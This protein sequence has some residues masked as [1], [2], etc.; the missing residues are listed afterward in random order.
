MSI[1]KILMIVS[2]T[3]RWDML[4]YNGGNV[5]T[6]NLDRLA[7]RSMVFERHYA[8]SFPTVPARYDYLTGKAAFADVGWGPLPAT[9]VSIASEM[10]TA[11]YTTLGVVDTPFYQANGY[12]YDR[13]FNFFYD[14]K[15]QLLGTPQYN[16]YSAPGEDKRQAQ[17][18]LP[19]FPITGKIKPDPRTGEVDCPAPI[20]ML[21]AAKCLEELYDRKFFALVDTWDP[22]EPWDPPAYYV[23]RYMPD[24]KGEHV[25]PPYGDYRK[26]GLSERD[27]QV[28]RACYC[29]ELELVDR[30]IGHLL[31]QLVYLG[32]EDSTAVVFISDHGFFLGEHGLLGKMVRRGPGEATWRR[33]PLYEEVAR[34]PLIIH[35]PGAKP[36][37]T[38]TLSCALDIAPTLMD[39]AGLT[40][41]PEMGGRSL[42]PA[43][44]GQRFKERAHVV[45]ALP[46]ANPGDSVKAVDD[47]MRTVVD[48]QPVTITTPEWSLLYATPDEPIELYDLRSDPKQTKNVADRNPD[49][50]KKL[51]KLYAQ[52]LREKN[53]SSHYINPR[54]PHIQ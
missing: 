35:I 32:I 41:R 29:G 14:M 48:W 9:D 11:G 40:P 46:F 31:D 2:D 44:T 3:V 4:G 12:R 49:V 7:A 27:L 36:G 28:A 8:S 50:I 33:S 53:V 13:G 30:W 26:H 37:R 38:S 54:L 6:P 42:L 39:M 22:H 24:Y 47:L 43:V 10:S 45:T 15:S 17:G 18:K 34:V 21:Q 5:R 51:L 25:H 16:A 52:D 23:K 20:T 1:D 19:Q